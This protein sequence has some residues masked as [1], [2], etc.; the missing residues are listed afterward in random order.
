M[1]LIG[2][3]LMVRYGWDITRGLPYGATMEVLLA[4]ISRYILSVCH[5]VTDR[6]HQ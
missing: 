1:G 5:A 6:V 3:T 4:Q 2:T